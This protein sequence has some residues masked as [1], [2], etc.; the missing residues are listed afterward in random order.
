MS[1]DLA[2][3]S[4]A[5]GAQEGAWHL[6]VL[7]WTRG[8]CRWSLCP[9]WGCGEQREPTF[10]SP[11]FLLSPSLLFPGQPHPEV[12]LSFLSRSSTVLGGWKDHASRL[13]KGRKE[14]RQVQERGVAQQ[15][16]SWHPWGLECQLPGPRA[17]CSS[18]SQL[19]EPQKHIS[20]NPQNSEA[21][22]YVAPLSWEGFR[23]SNRSSSAASL[24]CGLCQVWRRSTGSHTVPADPLAREPLQLTA[25]ANDEPAQRGAK[26]SYF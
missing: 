6:Q 24:P 23:G 11:L 19:K 16:C 26:A 21:G 15:S 7:P 9:Q 14:G 3:S 2:F 20:S 8:L 13:C 25:E 17:A 12:K 10:P 5:L 18:I 1:K 22:F 4:V